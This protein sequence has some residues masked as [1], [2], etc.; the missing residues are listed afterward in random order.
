MFGL[1]RLCSAPGPVLLSLVSW[2]ERE[3][4][5]RLTV[6]TSFPLMPWCHSG[7]RGVPAPPCTPVCTVSRVIDKPKAQSSS[8]QTRSLSLRYW[9]CRSRGN[10][11]FWLHRPNRLHDRL[12]CELFCPWSQDGHCVPPEAFVFVVHMRLRVLW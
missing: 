9:W 1:V 11:V 6:T 10:A 8:E 7:R 5:P 4:E 3:R 12:K 2:P